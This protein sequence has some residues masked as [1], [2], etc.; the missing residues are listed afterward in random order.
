MHGN[1]HITIPLEKAIVERRSGKCWGLWW[2]RND[3]LLAMDKY[4]GLEIPTRDFHELFRNH[5]IGERNVK[6]SR[7]E[8]VWVIW[9]S[10]TTFSDE[11]NGFT[12]KSAVDL[13]TEITKL[14]PKAKI[15]LENVK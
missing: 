6:E 10:T 2:I 13:H 14:K 8:R 11:K 12:T 15:S 3:F 4:D 1:F 7:F 9:C 5:I